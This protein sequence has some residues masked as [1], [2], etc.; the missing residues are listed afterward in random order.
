MHIKTIT[1]QGFKSYRD[2]IAVDPFSPGNNVIVG[3]NGSGKSN[4]FSAIRFVLSDAYVSMSREERQALLHD[5]SSS[6][7]TTLSAFVEIVFDNAD[8]RFPTNGVEVILRRTIGL[9]KDEYSIDRRS[10]SKA[11]VANLLEA[12]GFSRSN[13]YY[14]VPQ[15]R[16]T[17]LTNIKDSER[18]NLLKE[19]AGTRVYEQRR[20]E[21]LKIMT[22][23]DSKRAKIE[24]LLTYIEERLSELDEEKEEL[25]TYYEKDKD[26]R[27]LEY[28]IYQREMADVTAL[29]D[30]LEE[31]RNND[32]GTSAARRT[33]F[34]DRE[35]EL[36]KLEADLS[37][38]K[39]AQTQQQLAKDTL[40]AERRELS[41]AVAQLDA[42]V[43]DDEESGERTQERREDLQQRLDEVEAEISEKESE[44]MSVV[45]D[46]Q[47]RTDSLDEARER[48]ETVKSRLAFI[49]AKGGRSAQFR[50]QAER[51]EA[52]SQQIEELQSFEAAQSSRLTE[53]TAAQERAEARVQEIEETVQTK[54]A[55]LE[56]RKRTKDEGLATWTTKK[57]RRDELSEQRKELFKE[58]TKLMSSTAYAE[59]QFNLANRK[60]AATMDKTT[61][62]GLNS[63]MQVVKAHDVQGYHG[64]LYKLF[65]VDDRYQTAAEVTA[66][67]SLFHIV[68]DNDETASRILALMKDEQRGGRVTFMPLN[69]LKPKQQTFPTATDAIPLINKL[70]YDARFTPAMKQVFGSM[71]VCSELDVASAYV[72]S[73]GVNTITLDGDKVE[74]RGALTGGYHDPRRSRLDSI[75]DVTKWQDLL[76]GD[77]DRLKEVR[78]TT[79]QLEQEIT[80]LTGEVQSLEARIYQAANSRAPLLEELQWLRSEEQDARRD[81]AIVQREL[82]TLQ[83]NVK[84]AV[85]EREAL[86]QEL[87]TEMRQGLTPA[88]QAERDQLY[89]QEDAL[90]KE[91]ADLS[92]RVAELTKSKNDLE[93]DLDEQLKRERDILQSQ[94]EDLGEAVNVGG[95][96]AVTTGEASS[97][98]RRSELNRLKKQHDERKTALSNLEAELDN[99]G[100]RIQELQES[101]DKVYAA[102]LETARAIEKQQK[103]IDRY[104]SKRQ[105]FLEQKDKC[106]AHIRDLGVLPE[107]AFEKYL[108]T[109]MDR[110]VK[111]LH[112]VNDALKDYSHVNKKA[113][114]QYNNFTKQRDQLTQRQS[115]LE[116][117]AESIQELIEVLDQRKDEAIE[118]TFKQVSKNFEEVFARLVPAGRGKLIMQKRI[119]EEGP[120]EEEEMDVDSEEEEAQEESELSDEEMEEEATPRRGRGGRGGRKTAAAGKKGAKGKKV[121]AAATKAKSKTAAASTAIDHYT[122]ISIKVS[123]NSKSDEGLRIQQLSGG[124]KSLVALATVFAIQKCDPAPFY[125]FD[126]IDANLD[127][128]YRTSVAGMIE[129]L[130]ANAQFITTTFRPEMVAVAEKCYGVLFNAQKISSV[131]SIS[132]D[133]ANSFVEAAAAAV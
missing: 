92:A 88:E 36:A 106:N 67:T 50:N 10:A 15:G 31:H 101:H 131:R 27:C 30:E 28:A 35:K 89:A 117:S 5:S 8:G 11:D 116:K 6:T 18:L 42:Q 26:R 104:M 47:E 73:H 130:S 105:R 79:L 23:T 32:A 133:E 126:E 114:E 112:K 20:T 113:V 132:K 12:A 29:L 19:V 86:E 21:S 123:F 121:T 102:Q 60:L 71:L 46:W 94:L 84:A 3:R 41:R 54:E 124:Q 16:I 97:T 111:K 122:G 53:V 63:V 107:E 100:K 57:A 48:L 39:Q 90:G 55:A 103:N 37:E 83:R 82:T 127:A 44:L 75:R 17:H 51:D 40:V 110:L 96:R 65:T 120:D 70:Q 62:Q 52:L 91:V 66:N 9:K 1:I 85:A 14:I 2:Q 34:R 78:E 80:T 56:Q 64:P 25:K 43:R 128:Q 119:D 38:T 93:I 13:P 33:E 99:L 72:R 81:L 125:L 7:S 87:G 109:S 22:D 129:E 45:P 74:K 77:A 98:A 69:R 118:R 4:F 58:E 76:K 115:E 108:S 59:E 61:S 68:V 24:D 49:I 95:S